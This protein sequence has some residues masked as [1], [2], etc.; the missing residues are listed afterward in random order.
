MDFLEVS[1]GL[2][3]A[4]LFILIVFR[5]F[6]LD[7]FFGLFDLPLLLLE[8][9]G[10]GYYIP[11]IAISMPSLPIMP[12]AAFNL[13]HQPPTINCVAVY[14]ALAIFLFLEAL[15]QMGSLILYCSQH[16]VLLHHRALTAE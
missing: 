8:V 11:F 1:I 6:N 16:H 2:H 4:C 10:I 12:D 15:L 9:A 3:W 14:I 13:R 7:T 5:T